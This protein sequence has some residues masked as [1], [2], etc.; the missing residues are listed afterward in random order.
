MRQ[1]IKGLIEKIQWPASRAGID[2]Q[3]GLQGA[4]IIPQQIRIFPCSERPM[5]SSMVTVCIIFR[6]L[7]RG[8]E[9]YIGQ[10]R[11]RLLRLGQLRFQPGGEGEQRVK[12]GHD[13][14]LF[15]NRRNR[16]HEF[17]NQ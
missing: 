7:D 17:P 15:R 4:W 13:T 8:F 9:Q 1:Q 16:E 3:A 12:L 6:A 5:T 10:Q 2:L 11:L 14:G